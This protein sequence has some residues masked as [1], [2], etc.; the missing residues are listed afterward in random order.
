MP[1]VLVHNKVPPQARVKEKGGCRFTEM[2]FTEPPFQR[3]AMVFG[4]RLAYIAPTPKHTGTFCCCCTRMRMLSRAFVLAV[5][6]ER[7]CLTSDA[8]FCAGFGGGLST[9]RRYLRCQ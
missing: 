5:C 6:R 7:C 2:P 4:V 1:V 3:V 8:L 9:G